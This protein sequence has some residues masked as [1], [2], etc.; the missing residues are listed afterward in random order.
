MGVLFVARPSFL[1]PSSSP[2]P[3]VLLANGPEAENFV[4]TFD[5]PGGII[6]PVPVTPE[7]RSLAVICAV[8]G[9]FSAAAA[10]ATI[11]VIGKRA[12]SLVSVNYFAVTATL[13]SFLALVLHPDLSFQVPQT[14]MQWFVINVSSRSLHS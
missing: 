2:T 10:Y 6:T 12:H 8:W 7:Q 1:F 4:L 14:L 11:R 13:V 3:H 9:S 5:N